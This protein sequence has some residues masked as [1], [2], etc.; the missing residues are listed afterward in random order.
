MKRSK[1]DITVATY[2]REELIKDF[3]ELGCHLCEEA[4][5]IDEKVQKVVKLINEVFELEEN[6]MS[7][8]LPHWT[9]EEIRQLVRKVEN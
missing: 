2:S 1:T 5:V 8:I 4:R 3:P 7:H 9:P 6:F